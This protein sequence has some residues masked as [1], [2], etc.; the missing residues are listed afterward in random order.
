LITNNKN[1][2]GN[3]VV[4]GIKTIFDD[5]TNKIINKEL[6]KFTVGST[7]ALFYVFKTDGSFDIVEF[8]PGENNTESFYDTYHNHFYNTEFDF[9]IK[10]C[11]MLYLNNIQQVNQFY[12]SNFI[13]KES[14]E[15]SIKN[16]YVQQLNDL[17]NKNFVDI[18]I[19]FYS[20]GNV[21]TILTS[22]EFKKSR[23]SK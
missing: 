8:I 15:D 5:L 19:H 21:V 12:S 22:D 20:N 4:L 11:D 10:I 16:I 23:F 14:V 18:A 9:S 2:L 6:K 1:S 13:T 7:S 3:K 17:D